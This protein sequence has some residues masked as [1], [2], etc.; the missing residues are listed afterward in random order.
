MLHS[1]RFR[2]LLTMSIVVLAAVGTLALLT[3]RS[4]TD[5]FESY[6]TRDI[7][8]RQRIVSELLDAYKENV[9]P[10][11]MQALVEQLAQSSGE[12]LVVADNAG[13]V[14]I[15]S[16]GEMVGE[17][18]Q[19]PARFAVGG[20]DRQFGGSLGVSIPITGVVGAGGFP[21][22]ITSTTLP[23]D[24]FMQTLPAVP[25]TSPL[26]V[27]IASG[28]VVSGSAGS[29]TPL[30]VPIARVPGQADGVV[31]A[32]GSSP[33]LIVARVSQPG[34][35]P[36]EDR[37]LNS[38]NER[39]LLAVGIAGLVAILLTWL[40]SRRILGPVE[41]LTAAAGKMERGDL[42]QR[43]PVRSQDE[44]GKLAHAFNAMSD[45]LARQEQLRRNMV[46][47]VAHELRTPLSNIRGYLEAMRDGIAKPDPTLISSLHDEAMLLTRLVDDLQ[48]LEL[49]EAGQLRLVRHEIAPGEVIERA[50]KAAT[51]AATEKGLT[52][53]LDLPPDL[54]TVDADPERLSQVT[55]NL[56]NNAIAHTPKGGEISVSA[57]SVGAEVEVTIRDTGI[58]IPPEHLPS[59]FERF[60]RV[61]GSRTRA[62]GGAGL[63]LSIVKQ[64][65][66][67]HGGRVWAESAPGAGATFGFTLPKH[68]SS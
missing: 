40:L 10:E 34:G 11:R 36:G 63:G 18:L 53:H 30:F 23:L 4:T 67:M 48:E 19:W 49:A 60:Y 56:L 62:T 41:A 24:N 55:R 46:S 38:V 29:W 2:L 54:P 51:P 14:L 31:Q 27:P 45:G 6:V 64:L 15:D 25:I 57:R 22:V 13:K 5:Q 68:L 61:D 42:G 39:L 1:L 26:R 50:V 17:T 58:G 43:V 32:G 44:I 8:K 35:R 33:G 21:V 52:L 28:H 59:I 20:P 7:E 65:I 37:F 66:E 47:D 16:G 12:R 3:S 9:S